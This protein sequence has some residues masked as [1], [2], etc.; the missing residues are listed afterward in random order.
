MMIMN[1][2]QW[3]V[4]GSRDF[5][6]LCYAMRNYNQFKQ[7]KFGIVGAS[8]RLLLMLALLLRSW[9]LYVL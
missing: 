6:E 4:V 3:S 2:G 5:Q 9:I 7:G 1:D 8:I